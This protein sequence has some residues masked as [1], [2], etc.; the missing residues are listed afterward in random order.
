MKI[1]PN[2]IYFQTNNPSY[3]LESSKKNIET[4]IG[5]NKKVSFS[6]FHDCFTEK[7]IS[8]QADWAQKYAYVE[9]Y[10][11]PL[12]K[13]VF[14][15]F[16]FVDKYIFTNKTIEKAKKSVENVECFIQAIRRLDRRKE[17]KLIKLEMAKAQKIEEEKIQSEKQEE[18]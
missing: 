16:S 3:K 17:E 11:Q 1:P 10:A 7:E 4:K 5:V 8:Q 9:N 6:G 13:D 18:L 12:T 2:P 14:S 15:S